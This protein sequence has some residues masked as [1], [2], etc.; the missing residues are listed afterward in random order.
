MPVSS[1]R[2][3]SNSVNA[4]NPPAD[5]PMPTMG[6]TQPSGMETGLTAGEVFPAGAV[7]CF[8]RGDS[9]ARGEPATSSGRPLPVF[10]VTRH[11]PVAVEARQR[12]KLEAEEVFRGEH[13]YLALEL[14]GKDKDLRGCVRPQF[15]TRSEIGRA[16]CRERA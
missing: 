1:G 13:G 16:S 2:W 4:S 10:F 14:W 8:G 12:P 3:L 15:F 5:A 11:R 6:G 9:G 7:R